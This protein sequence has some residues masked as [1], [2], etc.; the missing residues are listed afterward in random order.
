MFWLGTARMLLR[1]MPPMPTQAMLSRSLGGVKP[2]PSTC[3]GTMT[4][5][6]P[7]IAAVSMKWRRDTP[8]VLISSVMTP[9]LRVVMIY[10]PRMPRLTRREWSAIV[11][12]GLMSGPI[13]RLGGLAGDSTVAGVR[14]G[15]Q[16][17]SFRDRSIERMIH[18]MTSIGLT[19]CELWQVHV[20]PQK[21]EG[22]TT[23]AERRE[24]LRKWR[25]SVPLQEFKDIRGQFERGGIKLTA[26]NLSFRDDF[27]DEEIDRGFEM[28]KALGVSVITASSN[29]TTAAKVDPFAEKHRITVGF[30][31]HADKK[32]NEFSGPEDFDTAL[33]GRS[34]Y[35]GIN[36]DI[37][38]FVA[39]GHDPLAYLDAYHDYIVS[40]H[41]KDRKR[42]DTQG[43][44]PFGEGDVPITAVL[45][46][47]RDR[48]WNIPANIEYE[49]NG[50]DTVAEVQRCFD[51][52][53]QALKG[54]AQ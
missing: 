47:L 8:S 21:F 54:T 41:I 30:H 10:L 48:K 24:A 35:I 53:K 34:K 16:S 46:R 7:V 39:A 12:G 27:T 43:N 26:Y 50:T 42:G 28:A 37:G 44:F 19:F 17:Y 11:F 36:L 33:R 22:A 9:P 29:V 18:G 38:H 13:A 5:P 52:C 3:R 40:L 45:Q 31:N 15:T 23:E 51:Y 4:I 20:E 14:I 1:P 25:L 6:A 32:P 2:R 49:Y